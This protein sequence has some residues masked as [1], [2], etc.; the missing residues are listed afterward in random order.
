MLENGE[1]PDYGEFQIMGLPFTLTDHARGL[2]RTAPRI[3][4]HTREV[5]DE[6]GYDNE[7]IGTLIASEVVAAR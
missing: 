7:R 5:L 6:L 4:E 2:R 1:D 3:G